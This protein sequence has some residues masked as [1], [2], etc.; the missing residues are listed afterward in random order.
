MSIQNKLDVNS[1]M[2][3]INKNIVGDSILI[4]QIDENGLAYG[5][6]K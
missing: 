5:K 1:D 6:L 4:S 3:L 2:L